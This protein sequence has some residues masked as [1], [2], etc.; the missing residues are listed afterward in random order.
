MN[1]LAHTGSTLGRAIIVGSS[2]AVLMCGNVRAQQPA[3]A[4]DGPF[5]ELPGQWSGTGKITLD[6]GTERLRC[7]SSNRVRGSSQS[8]LDLQLKCDSDTYKFELVSDVEANADGSITGRW[9]ERTRSVGGSVIGS[10]RGDRIQIHIESTAFAAD[11][12]IVA[13]SR[14][15]SVSINS[16]GG[17]V[18]AQT[19][20]ALTQTSKH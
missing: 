11:L 6:S 20:I 13:R 4:A 2:I 12:V 19:S 5:A 18:R 7:S 9:T 10:K 17:G 3:E 16:A 15:M 8:E 1:W 14:R